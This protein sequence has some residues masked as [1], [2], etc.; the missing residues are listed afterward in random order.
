MGTHLGR[1]TGRGEDAMLLVYPF[2]VSRSCETCVPCDD[3]LGAHIER[4]AHNG[5]LG[6]TL[7]EG[8]ERGKTLGDGSREGTEGLCGRCAQEGAES[9][10]PGQR[11]EFVH[12]VGNKRMRLKFIFRLANHTA[13][14]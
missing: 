4:R 14:I 2:Y 5:A 3:F 1:S 10:E 12:R 6:R 7:C 11:G 8:R 13:G 9:L